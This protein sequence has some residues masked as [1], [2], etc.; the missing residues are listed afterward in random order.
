MF[1]ESTEAVDDALAREGRWDGELRHTRKDG[2]VIVVSS[3]QALQRDEDGQ[4]LAIIELNSD[5]TERKRVEPDLAHVALL[6][7]TQAISATGGWDYDL[8]TGQLSWTDEVYRIYGIETT[9]DP[10]A[11][12]EAIAAYDLDSAPIIEAAFGRLVTEGEPYDLE[13]GLVRADGEQ[14]WV[15]TMGRPVYAGRSCASSA[16]SSTSPTAIATSASCGEPARSSSSRS[17]SRTRLVF[18]RPGSGAIVWSAELFRIFG[19]EAAD[20]PARASELLS[21]LYAEDADII[22]AAYEGVLAGDTRSELDFRSA[23]A[24][25]PSGSCT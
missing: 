12:P 8:A 7:R 15:R 16:T 22:K 25:A 9:G 4:P 3:R 19:R 11:V 24:T 14:R 2:T 10:T 5:I 13:L 20:G 1:P 17:G 18:H 21:Y 23:R 6:E